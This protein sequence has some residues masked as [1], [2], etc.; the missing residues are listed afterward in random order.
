[1][2]E[3]GWIDD[4]RLSWIG[5]FQRHAAPPAMC[6]F[7]S[8]GDGEIFLRGLDGRAGVVGDDLVVGLGLML[9][10]SLDFGVQGR[11]FWCFEDGRGFEVANHLREVVAYQIPCFVFLILGARGG[12]R[13]GVDDTGGAVIGAGFG[14]GDEFE[15]KAVIEIV[16]DGRE[17][18][19][20]RDGEGFEGFWRPDTG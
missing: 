8:H 9:E 16:A 7:H 1:M 19:F 14:D 15:K 5:G 10:Q 4:G 12:E 2:G 17:G 6:A 20:D 13:V 3:E 18:L 11:K